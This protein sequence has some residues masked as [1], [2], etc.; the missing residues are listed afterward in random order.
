MIGPGRRPRT[1][2]RLGPA[3]AIPYLARVHWSAAGAPL[4]L[5]QARDQRSQLYLA[6]DPETGATRTVHADEDPAWLDLFPGVP[7]LGAGR[8]LVRIA[9]EGGAR[10]LASATGR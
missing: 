3:S 8:R 5:V 6:V 10:V 1:R 2:G 9:D 7:A 4:L